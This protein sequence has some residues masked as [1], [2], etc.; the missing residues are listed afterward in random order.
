LNAVNVAFSEGYLLFVRGNTLMAQPFDAKRLATAGDAVP[1]AERIQKSVINGHA[2]FGVSANGSL[3]YKAGP[4]GD[5]AQLA[6]FDRSGKQMGTIGQ[7]ENLNGV[8]LSPDGRSVVINILDAS[9]RNKNLWIYDVTRGLKTRF[10][11]YAGEERQAIWSPD[12]RWIVF[13][14]FGNGHLDLYRK[15]SNGAGAEELLYSDARQKYPTSF[16]PDG[17]SFLYMVYVD[18]GSK[19]QL[20]ILPLDATPA[21][22]RKP[23]PFAPTAFNSS[24]GQF[25]PDGR[26]A[27]YASD[28]SQRNEI[29]VAPYPGPGA[30][31]QISSAGGDQPIW[32]RDGK[33]IF[34]VAPNGQMMAAEVS[35]KGGSLEVG[36]V[37]ALFGPIPPLLGSGYDVSADGQRFLVRTEA[38]Q[39]DEPLTLVRNWTALLKK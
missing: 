9:T 34:Y 11:F 23:V 4:T 21:G 33:E 13:N 29:Y 15:A 20:W 6:W 5:I 10:T 36:A 8:R 17:K 7:P 37:R 38:V 19:N 32:R 27:A 24:W 26:W 39:S 12:G 16:S 28:E 18:G 1:L 2:A 25:S 31:K 3:V 14:R 30:K 35:S 22:E